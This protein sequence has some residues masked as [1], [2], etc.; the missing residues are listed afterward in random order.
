M[1]ANDSKDFR[2]IV[3]DF[4]VADLDFVNHNATDYDSFRD[5]AK[6]LDARYEAARKL[7]EDVDKKKN[8]KKWFE[9]IPDRWRKA[10]LKNYELGAE[11]IGGALSAGTAARAGIKSKQRG[12]F[13]SGPHTSGKSYLAYA[14]INAFVTHGKLKPSQIKVIT[15]G[16]LLSLANGGFDTR[17]AFDS[18]FDPRYK[19]YLFDSLG[20]R[21]EYDDRRESPAL[22]RLIEEAYNRSALFICTSHMDLKLYE[23]GLPEQSAAKLRHMVKDGIIYTGKPL[24]GKTDERRDLELDVDHYNLTKELR[25]LDSNELSAASN[26]AGRDDSY[27]EEGLDAARRRPRAQSTVKSAGASW[28]DTIRPVK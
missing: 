26:S 5:F 19:C 4:K 9:Q 13:I 3:E 10:S 17:D 27:G 25:F 22:T 14:I 16:D 6:Q 7:K 28:K 20:T 11:A 8:M 2:R 18:I 15:E 24:Y 12:F 21:K 23:S 1:V